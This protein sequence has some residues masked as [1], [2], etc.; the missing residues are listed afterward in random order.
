MDGWRITGDQAAFEAAAG[1]LLRAD[2]TRNTTHLTVL[3]TL[4]RA[5]PHAYGPD[6]PVFGWF[7]GAEPVA[8]FLCTPTFP[9]LLTSVADD[10]ARALADALPFTPTG[11][12]AEPPAAAA[13]ADAWRRRTGAVPWTLMQQRLYRLEALVPPSPMP[14]GAARIATS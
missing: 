3:D 11:V 4:R 2:P 9:L 10:A 14:P 1:G 12:N 13:F 7:G 8:A 5:G 6:D